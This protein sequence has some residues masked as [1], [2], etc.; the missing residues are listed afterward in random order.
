MELDS[1]AASTA[2]MENTS[3]NLS[4]VE[5]E[6]LPSVV[7]GS[8][9]WH[10]QVPA[11]RYLK[12]TRSVLF[13]ICF[14]SGVGSNHRQ[15]FPETEKTEHPAAVQRCISVWYAQQEEENSHHCQT[16]R[17]SASSDYR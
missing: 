2:S 12:Q 17:K 1:P 8:E 15:G 7:I 9:A 5:G 10:G 13:T 3:I 6:P 16:S 4:N 14:S 11:V